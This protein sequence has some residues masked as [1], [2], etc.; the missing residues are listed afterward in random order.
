MKC[1]VLF[2]PEMKLKDI[3]FSSTTVSPKMGLRTA[4]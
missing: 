1:Q 2:A 4:A 3:N